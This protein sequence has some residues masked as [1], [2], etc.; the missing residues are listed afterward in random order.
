MQV[1]LEIAGALIYSRFVDL[2]L[3]NLCYLSLFQEGVSYDE[4]RKFTAHC[5][6]ECYFGVVSG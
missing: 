5:D 1:F 3:W 4:V 6:V 2:P